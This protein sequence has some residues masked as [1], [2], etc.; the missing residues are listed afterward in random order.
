MESRLLSFVDAYYLGQIIFIL[1]ML[2]FIFIAIAIP[3]L[4]IVLLIKAI[5]SIGKKNDCD[6][7]P[8]KNNNIY[9]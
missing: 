4:I 1:I 3:I 9:H 6:N 7:C 2:F 5:K 8:Y